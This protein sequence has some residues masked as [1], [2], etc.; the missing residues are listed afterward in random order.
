MQSE[1]FQ[2]RP[3]DDTS[4]RN[5]SLPVTCVAGRYANAVSGINPSLFQRMN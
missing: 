2:Q 3:R 1:P 5:Y 4:L